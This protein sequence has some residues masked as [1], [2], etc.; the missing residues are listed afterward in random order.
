MDPGEPDG[1]RG[2]VRP[3]LQEESSLGARDHRS[4]QL[5]EL[6]LPGTPKRRHAHA[7]PEFG[8]H[9]IV[10]PWVGVAQDDWAVAEEKVDVAV[11]IY[12]PHVG[13]RRPAGVPGIR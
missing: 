9:S 2:R 4:E 5:G 3:R 6:D 12:V 1:G 8:H 10:H 13:T 7:P 11:A